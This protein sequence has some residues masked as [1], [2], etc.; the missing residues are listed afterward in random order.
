MKYKC[1]IWGTILKYYNQEVLQLLP[2]KRPPYY[3]EMP[4]M[5]K[6]EFYNPRAGGKYIIS[7]IQEK[8]FSVAGALCIL[9]KNDNLR[10][11]NSKEKV[12]IS[13]YI[14]QENLNNNPPDLSKKMQDRNWLNK[15]LSIHIPDQDKR[16]ELLFKGLVKWLPDIDSVVSISNIDNIPFGTDNITPF[17]YALSYCER[18]GELY[19]LLKALKEAKDIE[20][21]GKSH[22]G[23]GGEEITITKQGRKRIKEPQSGVLNQDSDKAFI[24]MWI[25]SS[26]NSLKRSIEQA[27]KKAGYTPLRIDDKIHNNKIDDE[28]L[29]EIKKSKFM[30]CDITSED[31]FKPRASVFFEAGYAKKKGIP[32][33]WTCDK[34]MQEAH[35]Y[36]FDTRQYQCL[37]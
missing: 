27:I 34:K 21:E 22:V 35:F 5:D 18:L 6:C 29:S 25:D 24:A 4:Q 11:L 19:E 9:D 7:S 23:G 14:A 31:W 10:K 26:M 12:K 15:L 32:V 36:S 20:I 3:K 33:I 16:E 2:D 1:I 28:I 13:G 37:F 8:G 17:L 30:V